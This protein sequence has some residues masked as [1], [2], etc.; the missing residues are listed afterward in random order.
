[1]TFIAD[2]YEPFG[3]EMT[4]T[5]KRKGLR[6]ISLKASKRIRNISVLIIQTT[7]DPN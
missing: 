6:F 7:I 1:M 5:K 3:L 2:Y 4:S